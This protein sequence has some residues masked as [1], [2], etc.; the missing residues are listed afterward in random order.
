MS[1]NKF[2]YHSS[3]HANVYQSGITHSLDFPIDIDYNT[4]PAFNVLITACRPHQTSDLNDYAEH[5]SLFYP[6]NL[7]LTTSLELENHPIMDAVRDTL[8]PS[9]PAGHYLVATK[10]KLEVLV[11]GSRLGLQSRGLRND[12]RV[13]TIS[14]TLP[15][16]YR[17]GALVVRDVEGEEK[18][19]GAGGK[20][21]DIEWTAFL[22]DCEYEVETVQKG[23]RM[24]ILYAVFLKTFGPTSVI[25]DPLINPS[26]KFLDLVSPV[27]NASRGRKIAF[28]LSNSYGVN[29]SEVLAE[30][31]VPYVR[32]PL[33]PD[34]VCLLMSI[35]TAQ[36]R[37]LSS[38]SCYQV[39][40]AR[41]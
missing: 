13:A 8:F 7:P 38:L 18:F 3:L 22:A 26:D 30:S 17:G 32:Y 35:C 31:L 37:R 41:P 19:F 21:G 11:T 39:V 4:P 33:K 25:A 36:R 27:L 29:P 5:E 34:R 14:I 23:C 16:R 15:V 2:T 9:L 12:G 20:S 6:P 28:Y 10:D 40:Q 1:L 24:S